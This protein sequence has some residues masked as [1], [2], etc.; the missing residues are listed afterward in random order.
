MLTSSIVNKFLFPDAMEYL[1]LSCSVIG[2]CRHKRDLLLKRIELLHSLQFLDLSHNMLK[3]IQQFKLPP[4]LQVLKLNNTLMGFTDVNRITWPSSL[5]VLELNH[6]EID[7]ESL[8]LLYFPEN[9]KLLSLLNNR[10]N[11]AGLHQLNIPSKLLYLKIDKDIINQLQPRS[12]TFFRV[13]P[14]KQIEEVKVLCF[15]LENFRL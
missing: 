4:K 14:R 7:N 11:V 15:R 12:L 10:F 9:L 5:A 3:N 13:I 6:N 2:Y 1:N 8:N